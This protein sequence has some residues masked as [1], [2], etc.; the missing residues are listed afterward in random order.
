MVG[1]A[2][3]F[4][5]L[6]VVVGLAPTFTTMLLLLVPTGAAVLLFTTSA[7]ALV[8]L[9]SAPAVRGRVMSLYVL[10][11]LG[12][13]PVGAPV[14]G[15]VAEHFG[16]RASLTVGGVVCALSALVA[17]VLLAEGQPISRYR[18]ALTRMTL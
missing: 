14:V 16:P 2:L 4:G 9:G 18:G 15:L 17:A 13:T 8:Q 5:V 10:V 3:A 1:A 6:E 7:N 12:G 11:F